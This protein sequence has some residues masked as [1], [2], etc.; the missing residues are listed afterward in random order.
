MAEPAVK[1]GAAVV[2]VEAAVVVGIV[3]APATLAEV[4]LGG[5]ALGTA[6]EVYVPGGVATVNQIPDAIRGW[7]AVGT[8]TPGQVP[9]TPGGIAG[10]GARATYEI[11]KAVW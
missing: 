2:A 10:A 8:N 3:A 7:R 11:I 6:A 5:Q 1:A 4:K 9:M